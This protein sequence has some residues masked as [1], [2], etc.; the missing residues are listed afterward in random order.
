MEEVGRSVAS[1]SGCGVNTSNHKVSAIIILPHI[2][3]PSPVSARGT[4][5][6]QAFASLGFRHV[7]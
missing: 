4:T 6:S 5:H 1:G 2:I 7:I 3:L